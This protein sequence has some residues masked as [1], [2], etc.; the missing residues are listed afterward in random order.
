[1]RKLNTGKKMEKGEIKSGQA[2]HIAPLQPLALAPFPAWGSSA[3]AG[4][5]RLAR[6]KNKK[7]LR[8]VRSSALFL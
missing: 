7:T 5:V 3:G 4:R 2:T 8:I 6:H 1:M